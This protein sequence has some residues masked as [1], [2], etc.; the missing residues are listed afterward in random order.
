MEQRTLG[1]TG[2]K[3][4]VLCYG[5]A[6]AWARDLITD[7]FAAQLFEQ[8][9]SS[10]IRFFDTGHSYGKAEER[11]GMILKGAGNLQREQIVLSTKF[12]TR[13]L[14]GK[15]AHDTSPDWMKKS[16]ETSLKRMGT[17]Y[18]DLLYI[19]GAR[20]EDFNEPLLSALDD[21]KRQ[22][23]IR[24][25]GANTFDS[26][27]IRFIRQHACVDAVMLDYNVIMQSRE[28]E[29]RALYERGIGVVAGQAMGEG[30]FLN[31][32]FKI[33]GKKDLWYLARTLGRTSSRKLYL[34]GRRYRFLEHV[35]GYQASQIALKYVIDNPCISA[36]SVGT[37]TPAHLQ[38]NIDALSLT[39]PADVVE[40]IKMTGKRG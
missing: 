38:S 8:A 28:D 21:L 11:L 27:V 39:I 29:I 7:E 19:H 31:D 23:I 3:V 22:K 40:R 6:S 34:K 2:I 10:G 9:Y 18:I 16:V 17:D 30:V 5:C 33:R 35:P 37:C 1:K 24:A 25:T 12:G 26:Q 36:A 32:L 20:V 4:S 13:R 15:Y 14:D